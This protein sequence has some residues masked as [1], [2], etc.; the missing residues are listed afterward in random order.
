VR[1]ILQLLSDFDLFR[2]ASAICYIMFAIGLL[3]LG[4]EYHASK[5]RG[6]SD[7]GQ[8]PP[9]YFTSLAIQLIPLTIT[10]ILIGDTYVIATRAMTLVVVLITSALSSTK[11]GTFDHMGFR[12]GKIFW[13]AFVTLVPIFW[14]DNTWLRDLVR[15]NEAIVS[16]ISILFMLFFVWKGQLSVLKSLFTHFLRGNYSVR[17][18]KLQ[19]VRFFGFAF[20]A[21]AYWLQPSSATPTVFGLDPILLQGLIGAA[22]VAVVLIGAGIGYLFGTEARHRKQHQTGVVTA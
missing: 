17:R 19:W 2:F 9:G 11:D 18:L 13:I 7:I 5:V 16:W 8:F 1:E 6:E 20:Q 14:M 21:M 3:K 15:S 12:A 10:G 22:G 4:R